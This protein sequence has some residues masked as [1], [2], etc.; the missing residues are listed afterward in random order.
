MV[1]AVL[2]D[3]DGTF[4]LTEDLHFDSLVAVST[5]YGATISDTLQR[6][7]VGL[8]ATDVY[9][10]LTERCGMNIDFAAW[11]EQR[12]RY[13]QSHAAT[14]QPRPGALAVWGTLTA[15]GIQQALVS[16]SDRLIVT[17]N[18]EALGLDQPRLVSVARNDVRAGKPDPEPYLRAAYLLA[19][20]PHECVVIED[21]PMGS[22]AGL[23]AGMAVAVWPEDASLR[24]PDGCFMIDD[25]KQLLTLVEG[26]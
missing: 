17:I 19:V 16:N 26:G 8:S 3:I 23:A 20:E 18:I 10:H 25:I 5:R 6:D 13:Y 2:W 9:R 24:F 7:L 22:Q 15:K 12:Y 21:S 1:K 4:A 11:A 14:I